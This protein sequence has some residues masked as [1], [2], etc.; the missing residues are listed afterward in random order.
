MSSCTNS[1][2]F[3]VSEPASVR[4]RVHKRLSYSESV[5]LIAEIVEAVYPGQDPD[6]V[7]SPETLDHVAI[8]LNR[9]GLTPE[10]T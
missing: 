6:A 10:A 1:K 8:L 3:L 7:W 5:T 9:A 4:R 2:S